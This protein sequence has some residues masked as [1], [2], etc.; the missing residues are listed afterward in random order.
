VPKPLKV[1]FAPTALFDLE[2]IA[3][4][5]A[6]DNPIAA[7]Q[8]VDRL[9][10]AADKVASHPRSGRVVPELEDPKI[11]EVIVGEYRVIYRVEEKRLLV[12]TVIEG[13]R[14]LRGL[15]RG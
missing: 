13:H 6:Q 2:D 4:Y 1:E 10:A 3:E 8:L 12:L 9:V 7:E 11:R 5:I 15:P 14:R